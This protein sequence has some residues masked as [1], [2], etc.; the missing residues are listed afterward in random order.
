MPEVLDTAASVDRAAADSEE[1][2]LEA[3]CSAPS[4]LNFSSPLLHPGDLA[5]DAL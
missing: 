4:R 3:P 5:V 1:K 2:T